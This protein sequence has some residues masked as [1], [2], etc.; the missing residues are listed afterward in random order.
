MLNIL[1]KNKNIFRCIS[2]SN[3]IKK[4]NKT[5]CKENYI[6]PFYL[7]ILTHYHPKPHVFKSSS[8]ESSVNV[9]KF[10]KTYIINKL[11]NYISN[12]VVGILKINIIHLL[13][14]YP[15]TYYYINIIDNKIKRVTYIYMSVLKYTLVYIETKYPF[16]FK[17]LLGLYVEYTNIINGHI[18]SRHINLFFAIGILLRDITYFK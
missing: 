11:I 10:L 4:H 8:L 15:L 12:C 18:G 1:K 16:C 2:L 13:N 3:A 9:F 5:V 6:I 17:I 7:C 14:R